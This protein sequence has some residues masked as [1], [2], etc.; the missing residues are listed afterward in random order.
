LILQAQ[1]KKG[2][3]CGGAKKAEAKLK[4][5]KVNAGSGKTLEAKEPKGTKVAA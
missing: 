1:E 3:T 4:Q 2:Q 5:I